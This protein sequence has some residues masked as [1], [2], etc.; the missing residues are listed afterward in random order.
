MYVVGV[1]IVIVIYVLLT[2]FVLHNKINI[3]KMFTAIE[4]RNRVAWL[5][6]NSLATGKI[7]K[8]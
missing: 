7:L 1:A 2:K 4:V 6:I 5:S 8:H 3:I